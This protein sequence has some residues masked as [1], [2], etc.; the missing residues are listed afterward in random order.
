MK[1]QGLLSYAGVVEG[2]RE[3]V[4]G[5]IEGGIEDHG[6]SPVLNVGVHV[7]DTV[8]IWEDVWLCRYVS[9]GV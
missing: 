3:V 8:I 7:E 6:K 9:V 1:H 2:E 4:D 5:G